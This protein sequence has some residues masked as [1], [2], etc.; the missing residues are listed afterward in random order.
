M[1]IKHQIKRIKKN[2]GAKIFQFVA[3][4]KNVFKKN[5]VKNISVN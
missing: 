3:K 1:F 5:P 4:F 2:C